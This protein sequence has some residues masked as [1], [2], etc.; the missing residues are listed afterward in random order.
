MLDGL[1]LFGREAV[2]QYRVGLVHWPNVTIN[3]FT[4]QYCT[5]D[6]FLFTHAN[7]KERRVCA[8]HTGLDMA[9]GLW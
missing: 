2:P 9:F 6:F 7:L 4:Y 1:P 5:V 8:I 3:T